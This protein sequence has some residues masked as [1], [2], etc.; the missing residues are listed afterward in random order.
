MIGL[1]TAVDLRPCFNMHCTHAHLDMNCKSEP[2][3]RARHDQYTSQPAE[4]VESKL[5]TR[6]EV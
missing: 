3:D 5:Q 2:G 1:Y 4:A 6:A